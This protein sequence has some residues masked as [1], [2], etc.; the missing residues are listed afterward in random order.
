MT[1]KEAKKLVKETFENSFKKDRFCNFAQNLLNKIDTGKALRRP[2][3]GSYISK[4][5]QDF[6]RSLDRIGQYKDPNGKI[7]DILIVKL[8]KETSLE[9]ART[10]QRNYIAKYLKEDRGGQLKD[11]ALT[12][13]VS[14]D[15]K[16]W[17][18]SLVKIDYKFDKQGKIKDKLTPARRY[19]FLLGK[20]EAS[21]TAQSCLLPI[22]QNDNKNPKLEDLEQAFSVEKITKEFFEKYRSLFYTLKEALDKII[23]EDDK[24]K[25]HFV[26][27]GINSADFSKKTVGP[28][29]V[30]VFPSKKRAGLA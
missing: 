15:E 5:F 8:K 10:T 11:G 14:P 30:P 21:H 18:F 25:K 12:A 4:G 19:S 6:I 1:E 26:D 27:K 17:R 16:D 28:N 24:L 9:R 22:F 7:I 20:D 23:A 3:T 13:F 2:Q 29:C